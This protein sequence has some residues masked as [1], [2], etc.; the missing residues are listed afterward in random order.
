MTKQDLFDYVLT[1]S[2][3]RQAD[4]TIRETVNL[5]SSL[6]IDG[7]L[8]GL[9]YDISGVL[10]IVLKYNEKIKGFK[11]SN[12]FQDKEWV[13]I[14]IEKESLKTISEAIKLSYDYVCQN[15]DFMALSNNSLLYNQTKVLIEKKSEIE[16]TYLEVIKKITGKDN[17]ISEE[18]SVQFN[19]PIE[20]EDLFYKAQQDLVNSE[21]LPEMKKPSNTF[22][23][24]M[25]A[26]GEY[27]SE[28]GQFAF[29]GI[30]KRIGL[31]GMYIGYFF[32]GLYIRLVKL[33]SAD[34][35]DLPI[36]SVKNTN[37]Y[38]SNYAKDDEAKEKEKIN[39]KERKKDK[40]ELIKNKKK[41]DKEL[42][43]SILFYGSL[44]IIA[45]LFMVPFYIVVINSLKDKSDIVTNPLSLP[46]KLK[47][48]N[49]SSGLGTVE[50]VPAFFR[51]LYVTIVSTGLILLTSSMAA[52]IIVRV[53]NK[54]T[55]VLYYC[56]LL[57]MVVPFQ[58][59]MKPM[60]ALTNN[61]Y[62]WSSLWTLPLVYIGFG[63]GLSIFMFVGF[64]K[65]IPYEIEEAACVDGC[66]PTKT[67]FKV[68]A[69]IMKPTFITVA[70]LNVMWIWND[71]LLPYSLI[72]SDQGTIPLKISAEFLGDKGSVIY[73]QMMA[74]ILVS[75]IPII[76]FYLLLQKYIIKGVSDGA[77]KS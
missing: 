31:M 33:F 2:N 7:I 25:F 61:V 6:L 53:K 12:V 23:A 36:P 5:P 77:V 52:W 76:I 63:A 28:I 10:K 24:I 70:I 75:I 45:I 73:D 17:F 40:K 54:F 9:V 8:F 41:F 32:A 26:L 1:L 72:D 4:V 59:V 69:P 29:V 11:N 58:L 42:V 65:G 48:S 66:S 44:L 47:F 16:P 64:I 20:V 39:A 55:Q 68:I 56:F 34:K 50:F 15:S 71:Y 38:I 3:P 18:K 67:F 22:Q 74:V 35:K 49:Y 13:E 43:L 37:F 21:A 14:V 57:A 46:M 30:G 27:F 19:E 60:V 51:S 62:H